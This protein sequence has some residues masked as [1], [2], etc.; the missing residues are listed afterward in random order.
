M[1]PFVTIARDYHDFKIIQQAL[2]HEHDA[3]VDY[4][5]IGCGYSELHNRGYGYYHA[6]FFLK[7][8]DEKEIKSTVEL[9]KE[10]LESNFE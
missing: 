3:S 8:H 9:W 5:E 1:K 2:E 4:K 7:D 10:K 6:I